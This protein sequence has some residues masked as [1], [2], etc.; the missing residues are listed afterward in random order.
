MWPDLF[1]RA[2]AHSRLP[3]E[4]IQPDWRKGTQYVLSPKWGVWGN[5]VASPLSP[6]ISC[7]FPLGLLASCLAG[8]PFSPSLELRRGQAGAFGRQGQEVEEPM[9]GG[10]CESSIEGMSE[11]GQLAQ[12]PWPNPRAPQGWGCWEFVVFLQRLGGRLQTGT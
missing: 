2:L 12:L 5:K 10:P 11:C 8:V 7:G 9:P 1:L 4:I 3:A 6:V